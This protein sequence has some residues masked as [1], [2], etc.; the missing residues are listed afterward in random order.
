MPNVDKYY[1]KLMKDYY[2]V[3]INS[4]SDAVKAAARQAI[5]LLADLPTTSKL[6]T[7]SLQALDLIIRQTMGSDFVA[8]LDSPLK[9]FIEATYRATSQEPEFN[10]YNVTFTPL[11][12]KNIIQIK[13]TQAFW[14]KNH[15]DSTVAD[16]LSNILTQYTQDKWS[17]QQL[18][19][20]LKEHFKDTVNGSKAYFKGL[21]EH[22]S[23]KIREFARIEKYKQLGAQWYQ[24]VAV[25]DERTSDICR[26]LNGKI[27]A[28]T[29]AVTSMDA[30]MKIC[31]END[32]ETAKKHLKE[33][34]PFIKDDQLEYDANGIPIGIKG[35]YSP[36][37]PFHWRCRSRTIMVDNPNG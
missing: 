37:P 18:G 19:D 11:D 10:R 2:L 9:T 36:F 15:Y 16:A 20:H 34:A 21:A 14:I 24:I 17:V 6:S 32:Y 8:A 31:E 29:D 26:A 27:F 30:Q 25:M 33:I 4:Y 12:A 23:L 7:G 28:V 5:Q 22:T 3:L 1:D 13:Q 35:H